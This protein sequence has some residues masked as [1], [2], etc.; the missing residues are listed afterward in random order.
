M[1]SQILYLLFSRVVFPLIVLL[2][3]P[4][5]I[6]GFLLYSRL[7]STSTW[8]VPTNFLELNR[9]DWFASNFFFAGF[10]CSRAFM[11][12]N[13]QF[14]LIRILQRRLHNV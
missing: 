8:V 6:F 9:S 4:I 12:L 7:A 11:Y 10:S 1:H 3:S 2:W 5:Q 14:W 13:I